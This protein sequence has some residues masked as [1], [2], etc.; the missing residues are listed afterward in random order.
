MKEEKKE[1]QQIRKE[2]PGRRVKGQR[3]RDRLAVPVH[4]TFRVAALLALVGGFLEGGLLS[5]PDCG[6][7]AG[8]ICDRGDKKVWS[9]AGNGEAGALD[10]RD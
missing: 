9:Y 4:E 6:I 1:E 3:I 5:D 8:C 7:C 2:Q 10:Y